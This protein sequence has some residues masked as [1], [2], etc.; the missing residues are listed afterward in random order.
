MREPYSIKDVQ[1]IV[2]EDMNP[3]TFT[4][5]NTQNR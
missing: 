2:T 3:L 4:E 1:V 5:D